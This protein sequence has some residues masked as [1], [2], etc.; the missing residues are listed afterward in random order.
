MSKSVYSLIL[1]D[2]VVAEIDRL[3]CR[4]HVS[5]S[6]MI[7]RIL[8]KHVSVSTPEQRRCEI[9]ARLS[10]L[11]GEKDAFMLTST[12]DGTLNLRSVLAYKYRPTVKYTVELSRESSEIG[13]LRVALRTQ[14][15]ALIEEF[16]SFCRIWMRIETERIGTTRYL[17]DPARFVRELR[18]RIRPSA[19]AHSAQTLGELI[20]RYLCIFDEGLKIY[21]SLLD[22]PVLA[23]QKLDMLYAA[24]AETAR[25][26][27]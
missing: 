3:A 15:P 8:A 20:G 13:R 11:L 18:L 10:G 16:D 5:R 22:A 17:L 19:D 23:Y 6:E 14:N 9:V 4:N 21:F 7:T 27:L 2:D 1:N 12:G 26:L 24:Y 25:E